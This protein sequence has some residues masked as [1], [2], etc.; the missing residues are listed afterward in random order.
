VRDEEADPDADLGIQA[1]Q[2]MGRAMDRLGDTLKA[3]DRRQQVRLADEGQEASRARSAAFQAEQA[4]HMAQEAAQ[5]ALQAAKTELRSSLLW[6]GFGGLGGALL[7]F[8]VGFYVGN[9]GGWNE[10]QAAGYA[11]ARDETAAAAWANTPNGRRALALDQLGSLDMLASCS[12]ASWTVERQ[13][14]HRV[15]FPPANQ[16][17][18]AGWFIP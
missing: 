2:D 9:H 17:R 6:T 15:C 10:G 18:M 13:D 12:G 7:A 5:T 16:G 3:V 4:A 14:G 8:L 11:S 1:F